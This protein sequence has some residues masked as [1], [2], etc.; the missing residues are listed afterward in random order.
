MRPRARQVLWKT[1]IEAL[2]LSGKNP[3]Q[4]RTAISKQ[5]SKYQKLLTSFCTTARLEA[6]LLV[7][8]QVRG[9]CSTTAARTRG[10]RCM[11]PHRPLASVVGEQS[12]RGFLAEAVVRGRGGWV[13]TAVGILCPS[14]LWVATSGAILLSGKR[15][16]F[17]EA[18][19]F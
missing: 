11:T 5:M 19:A 10:G 14:A 3:N 4:I 15:E 9:V 17:E 7:D 6:A 8:V 12:G 13:H 1:L 2:P 16:P 18:R